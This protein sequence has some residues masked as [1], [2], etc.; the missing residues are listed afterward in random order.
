MAGSKI[1][2]GES[3]DGRAFWRRPWV[4]R[5]AA[6]IVAAIVLLYY[7]IGMI[8]ANKI[9]D[10]LSF[11]VATSAVPEGGSAAVAIAAAMVDREVNR[12]GWVAN[13]PF[14]MPSGALDNMPNFQQGIVD[15]VSTFTI[16]LRDHL[17]RMRGSSK[18]DE[19]LDEALSSMQYSGTKW[20]FDLSVSILPTATSEA[21]YR[22]GIKALETYNAGVA[23]G[24]AAY[25]RRADNLQA[26]IN[27]IALDVGSLSAALDKQIRENEGSLLDFTCDDLFYRVKGTAY[28]Y[29]LILKALR[30]DFA[31]IIE[32]RHLGPLWDSAVDG[33]AEVGSLSPLIVWN[34]GVDGQ[35]MPNHLVS[36][37]FFLLRARS[38]LYEIADILLK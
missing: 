4:W 5:S 25:D 20:V 18:A 15:A 24:T 28:A 23:A 13:D 7:P 37:G 11:A 17:G 16:E 21:Q 14:F 12:N 35:L 10:D 6:A 29:Y 2:L 22:K 3:T 31:P 26:V 19:N 38:Q 36:E 27:R 33:F 9:D 32:E 34:G 30:S 1:F 8:V